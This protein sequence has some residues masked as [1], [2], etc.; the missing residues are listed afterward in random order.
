MRIINRSR[1]AGKT[2][3]LVQAAYIT[4]LPIIVPTGTSKEYVLELAKNM[5]VLNF[6]DVYTLDEWKRYG[7]Y[8]RHKNGVLIDNM[9]LILDR[10]L[11]DYL[12][13]PVITGTISIPMDKAS[14]EIR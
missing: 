13:A 10:I 6:I 11:S 4:G 2:A 12:N 1:G 9:D 3:M 7:N 14:M 8:G 5:D